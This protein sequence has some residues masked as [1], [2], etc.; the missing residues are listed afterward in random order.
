MNRIEHD[1]LGEVAVPA[2]HHWGAQT[3]RSLQNFKIGPR[4]PISLIRALVLLKKAAATANQQAGTVTPLAAQLIRDICNEILTGQY[5]AEFPLCVYQTGSG[6]QTNM[7]VNEVIA[8]LVNARAGEKL[9]HPNDTINR[10]QSTNDMFP[11]AI[12][13]AAYLELTRKLL[14]ALDQLIVSFGML[15]QQ[16]ANIVKI[17]RT[18]LQDAVP[19]TLGQEIGA[20]RAC[21][22]ADAAYLRSVLDGLQQLAVGGTAV[23]TGLNAPQGFDQAVC[24]QLNAELGCEF[25][26]AANKFS[27]L[28]SKNSLNFAHGA[29]K[30]LAA[31]LFKIASDIRLL[32]SGPRCGIGELELPANEPGSS[33]MP[34]KVNPTQCE[35]MIMVC[36]RV[37][38][39][40]TAVSLAAANGQLELNVCMP[41]FADVFLESVSLLSDAIESFDRLCVRGIVPNYERISDNLNRSLMLVTCLTP[42]I[43][44]ENAAKA[45]LHAHRNGYTLKQAVLALELLTEQEFDDLC[46]PERMV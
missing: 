31:D 42:R 23:G 34:G 12:H 8:H 45:A 41:L 24:D 20:W 13:V 40:D 32:A 36:L 30:T 11:S 38:G 29:L 6:T 28:G 9:V 7:N 19:V 16:Y 18:H 4:M 15:E 1:A 21:C 37:M 44:Y 5:D 26:P 39:N 46:R 2:E 27:A 33:I 35:A 3:Q 10:S 25:K 43:G 17:G 22:E 14:P